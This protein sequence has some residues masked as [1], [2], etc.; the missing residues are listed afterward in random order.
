MAW[1]AWIPLLQK[2]NE[3][4]H[5]ETNLHQPVAWTGQEHQIYIH[6]E[7]VWTI[8]RIEYTAFVG[9]KDR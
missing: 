1:A 8:V 5:F 7:K 3:Q 6:I 4:L 9:G 2:T